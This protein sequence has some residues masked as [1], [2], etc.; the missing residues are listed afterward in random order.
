MRNSRAE[1]MWLVWLSCKWKKPVSL[2]ADEQ[3][4]FLRQAAEWVGRWLFN[5]ESCNWQGE[6]YT[7]IPPWIA[8]N[9]KWNFVCH[10]WFTAEAL[11][12]I[13]HDIPFQPRCSWK[14]FLTGPVE[15]CEST[16]R[17]AGNGNTRHQSSTLQWTGFLSSQ[18]VEQTVKLTVSHF[19]QYF[20]RCSVWSHKMSMIT[21]SEKAAQHQWNCKR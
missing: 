17:H 15:G 6:N 2:R 19:C 14:L 8:T 21:L 18:N 16:H 20:S 1:C 10:L 13:C 12:P 5:C 9:S 3:L 11:L 7:A 4:N